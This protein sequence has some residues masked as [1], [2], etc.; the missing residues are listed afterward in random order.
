M[1]MH[2]DPQLTI[3]PTEAPGRFR[4]CFYEDPRQVHDIIV[5]PDHHAALCG[6][7]VSPEKLASAALDLVLAW[8]P[9]FQLPPVFSLRL[10]ACCFPGLD[11]EL[12]RRLNP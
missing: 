2:E 10:L 1:I 8:D 6:P 3:E 7:H 11:E 9:R 5:E 4:L 12:R